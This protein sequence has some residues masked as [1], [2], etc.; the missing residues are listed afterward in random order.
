MRVLFWSGEA[1]LGGAERSLLDL[2]ASL[3]AHDPRLELEL[4]LG[5]AGPLGER[6]ALEGA[7]VRVLPLPDGLA[8][9]GDSGARGLG[10]TLARGVLALPSGLAY[11]REARRALLE[12]GPDLVHTNSLKTHLLA[13]AL[14][15][16]RVP[17]VW[18]MRDFPGE[19]ALASRLLALVAGRASACVAISEAVRADLLRVCPSLP[20]RVVLNA[21]DLERFSPEG[22]RLDLDAQAGLPP[23]EPGAARVGVV[24]GF[25]RWKGQDLFLQAL[26]R[27]PQGAPP[28]RGYVVGGPLYRTEGSQFSREELVQ[29]SRGLGLADRVGFVPFQLDAAPVLRA[30]DVVVHPST[31]PEPFGRTIAEGMATGRAVIASA[32]GGSL[33]L[34]EDGVEALGVEPGDATQLA[35]ALAALLADPGRRDALGRSARARARV[36]FDRARLGP[37]MAAVYARVLAGRS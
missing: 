24:A 18:H 21:I 20:T 23:A 17:V 34:F 2:V 4:L 29:L 12:H 3:R 19:R 16:D 22:P 27:L 13:A 37:E 1:V 11:A 26:A 28:W 35:S 25:G 15:G 9:L 30:L 7:G 10:A 14:V 31:R 5:A 36:S 6:A 8:S 32:A 33:E